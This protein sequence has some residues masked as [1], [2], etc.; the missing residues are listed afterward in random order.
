ML[1][2]Y[3]RNIWMLVSIFLHHVAIYYTETVYGMKRSCLNSEVI[4]MMV[5]RFHLCS[6]KPVGSRNQIFVWCIHSCMRWHKPH[7]IDFPLFKLP[8]TK[9]AIKILTPNSMT[10]IQAYPCTQPPS[11]PTWEQSRPLS[12]LIQA[13]HACSQFPTATTTACCSH[14][15]P[16]PTISLSTQRVLCSTFSLN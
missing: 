6:K 5:W 4:Y 16:L 11:S 13:L 2:T 1:I 12:N 15:H 9:M 8:R 7:K 10:Y 14:V 3:Y